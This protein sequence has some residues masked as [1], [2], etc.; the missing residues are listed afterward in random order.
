MCVRG[1]ATAADDRDARE[2]FD[3]MIADIARQTG[4]TVHIYPRPGRA[5][6]RV[7]L[8]DSR[9]DRGTQFEVVQLE[10]DGTVR[11]IGHDQGPRVSEIFGEDITSYEWVYVIAPDKVAALVAL[12][13]G[14]PGDDALGLLAGYYER[15]VGRISDLLKRPEIAAEFSNWHS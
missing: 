13:G 15:T 5:I 12:L 4:G 11:I 7:V 10:D 14:K 8:W 9:D 6:R 1:F 3:Q 2:Q